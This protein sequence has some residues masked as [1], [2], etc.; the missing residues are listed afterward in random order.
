MTDVSMFRMSRVF[1][2][3][4]DQTKKAK[5]DSTLIIDKFQC[6]GAD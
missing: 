2:A 1:P 4:I 6:Y 5:W 3:I